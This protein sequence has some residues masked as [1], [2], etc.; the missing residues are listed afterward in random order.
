MC[1]CVWVKISN[2]LFKLNIKLTSLTIVSLKMNATRMWKLRCNFACMSAALFWIK[3]RLCFHLKDISSISWQCIIRLKT[4]TKFSWNMFR[5]NSDSCFCMEKR[6]IRLY[7]PIKSI[8]A[9]SNI[10]SYHII[11]F[12]FQYKDN[13]ENMKWNMF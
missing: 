1:S 3:H 7:F 13:L 4:C 12:I 9:L 2:I 6:E 5:I 8:N 10:Y 11:K